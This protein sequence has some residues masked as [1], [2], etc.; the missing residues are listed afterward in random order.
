MEQV[1]PKFKKLLFLHRVAFICNIFF[2]FCMVIRYTHADAVI[3]QPIVELSTILGWLFSPAINLITL[4][5]SL[6]IVLKTG[7][8]LYVPLWLIASNLIFFIIEIFY[9]FLS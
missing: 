7:K 8:G 4:A 1:K 6:I 5:V 3:P 9:F 2:L